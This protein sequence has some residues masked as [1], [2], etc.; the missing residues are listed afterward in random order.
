M[1]NR[2]VKSNTLKRNRGRERQFEIY[3]FN[4]NGISRKLS[5]VK[6]FLYTSKPDVLCLCETWLKKNEPKFI[7]YNSIWLNRIGIAKGGLGILVREDIDYRGKQL[8]IFTNGGLELQG[9][10]IAYG[11]ETVDIINCYNPQKNIT[12]EEFRYYFLQLNRSFVMVGDYN[13]HLPMWDKRGRSNLTGRNLGKAME[14]FSMG[15]LNDK[16]IP[17]YID[18]RTGTT[19]CLD[20]CIVSYNLMIVGE[21]ER[22]EDLGSDHFPMKFTFGMRVNKS[23]LDVQK[24]WKIAEANWENFRNKLTMINENQVKPLDATTSNMLITN[25]ILEA[26]RE[27]IPMT[28]GTKS[29][30]FYTPWW[31]AEC[32]HA[33]AERKKAK[34]KLW[35]APTLE[36]L[37]NYK[38][39][40]AKAKNVKLKKTRDSWAEFVD[41]MNSTTTTKETWNKIKSIGGLRSKKNTYAM[42]GIPFEDDQ[43]K[44]ELFVGHFGRIREGNWTDI[45]EVDMEMNRLDR[46]IVY[47][48]EYIHTHEVTAT[49][50]KLKNTAPGGDT[51][52]NVFFKKCPDIIV[53]E[54]TE[55]FNTSWA[56]GCVPDEWK[57]G[58]VCPI[59][60]PGKDHT[61]VTGY[62]PITMLPCLGKLLERVFLRRLNFHLEKHK[63]LHPTQMGFRGGKST[64][65][66]LHI[67]TNEIR[68]ALEGRQFCIVVYLDIQGAYDGVWHEGLVFKMKQMGFSDQILKWVRNYLWGRTMRVRVGNKLS[69]EVFL[70]RGLPQGAAVSPM[71]FNIMLHDLPETP[72]G[73]EIV[74]Y[75]DD[76]TI[77]A[78]GESLQETKAILQH[79]ANELGEW[80]NKWRFELNTAKCTFQIFSRRKINTEINIKINN[81]NISKVVN[82]KV[83]GIFLDSPSLNFT[84]HIKYLKD[85]GNKRVNILK[86]ITTTK[87]GGKKKLLRR[88]Y[89]SF[90]RSK[91]EYG[92]TI[93]GKLSDKNLRILQVLQNNALRC[94]LGARKTSPILSLEVEAHVPP[95]EIRFEALLIKGYIKYRQAC[96]GDYITEKLGITNR[97]FRRW[98]RESP[99]AGR[100]EEVFLQRGMSNI[101]KA[102][103]AM[104]SSIPPVVDMT[105]VVSTELPIKTSCLGMGQQMDGWWN[106]WLREQYDGCIAIYTDGSRSQDGQVSAAMYVPDLKLATGWKLNPQHTVLGAE[107]FAIFQAVTFANTNAI[108][109]D[110]DIMVA[111][112]SRSAL[113]I[114]KNTY[115]PSYKYIA[116]QIQDQLMRGGIGRIKLQ[117]VK[118]HCG[119][120]GNE[121]ADRVANL[122][123]DNDKSTVST[124]CMEEMWHQAYREVLKHWEEKWYDGVQTTGTGSFLRSFRDSLGYRDWGDLSRH[125][126]CTISRLRIGHVGVGKHLNRFNM[127]DSSLCQD[128][129]VEDT[130]EH[131]LLRCSR[132]RDCRKIY[133]DEL[134]EIGVQANLRSIMGEGNFT[135]RKVKKI[136]MA[137]AK[138]IRATDRMQDL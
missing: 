81:R 127:R 73:V 95:V 62:R 27:N 53:Q 96:Q 24:K 108:L 136:I 124:L 36:N 82:Q 54:I 88:V 42:E 111:T 12:L 32:M 106:D 114:I 4:C 7:G 37:I 118:S 121:V 59:P 125:M 26:A 29:Y 48:G 104:V 97:L 117:W 83:L 58:I 40:E 9:I 14:N 86:A 101:K 21:C 45:V 55:V 107:L 100:I 109:S 70:D 120:K 19:S 68:H 85:E 137:L 22:G 31:D 126:E 39:C 50:K 84:E 66:A 35:R 69:R 132:Y 94:I 6:L 105:A 46:L 133:F 98:V 75:A 17:T 102:T 74:S 41:S 28:S 128:C 18:N 79:Y 57:K 99:L 43:A 5:E 61:H 92:C 1:I 47:E 71:L 16:D 90:I 119:I 51:I 23:D 64:I 110:K 2:F 134:K 34:G 122:G 116:Y 30:N 78:R 25:K 20:L 87:W 60:K 10:Q 135:K 89:I 11:T 91:L 115:R 15:L 138:Y 13:A 113:D 8:N 49:I 52:M 38:K 112:D 103:T 93:F 56:S 131:Y 123:H 77:T 80:L 76:I 44:A 33:V 63:L 72:E 65:D 67:I 130:V 129:E 3:Q